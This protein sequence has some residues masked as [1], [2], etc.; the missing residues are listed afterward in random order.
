MS[1]AKY[2]AIGIDPGS[3]SGAIAIVTDGILRI[4]GISGKTEQQIEKVF[5]DVLL[6]KGM[7]TLIMAV[8]ERVSAMPGQGSVSGFKFGTN[9]GFLRGC[10]VA[11]RIP[12]RD[13]PPKEWQKYYSM[14]KKKEETDKAWKG[15]LLNVAQ[16]IFP[17]VGIP[18]YSGDAVLLSNFAKSLLI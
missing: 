9:Y 15:R 8:I 16:N 17:E 18:L 7:D 5:S 11:N 1:Y 13:P 10:L 2:I 12:F 4:H 6:D 3:S 14:V